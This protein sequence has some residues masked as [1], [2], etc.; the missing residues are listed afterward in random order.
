MVFN[1]FPKKAFAQAEKIE[2]G[3]LKNLQL[4]SKRYFNYFNSYLIFCI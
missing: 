1:G 4:L 2:R 3:Y